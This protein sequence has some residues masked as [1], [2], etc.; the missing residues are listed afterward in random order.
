MKTQSSKQEEPTGHKETL[1]SISRGKRQG[2]CQTCKHA[3][4][5]IYIRNDGPPVLQCEEFEVDGGP[6]AES[7]DVHANESTRPDVTSEKRLLGLCSNCEHRDTCRF[8][9]PEG[10]VWHCEEYE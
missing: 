2:L 7:L 5:C 6:E 4:Y 10:G 8:P 1:P 3:E 9:K